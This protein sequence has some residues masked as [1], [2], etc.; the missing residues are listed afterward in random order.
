M[1]KVEKVLEIETQDSHVTT[2][3]SFQVLQVDTA[4]QVE[5]D[6]REIEECRVKRGITLEKTKNS[7][8][9]KG[10]ILEAHQVA[11]F[12]GMAETVNSRERCGIGIENHS[13]TGKIE[14]GNHTVERKTLQEKS[15]LETEDEAETETRALGKK[16]SIPR[17][18][19]KGKNTLE[20]D[21][22]ITENFRVDRVETEDPAETEN[23]S[24]ICQVEKEIS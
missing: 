22:A 12:K 13:A 19:S 20:K 3:I 23:S 24:G 7:K 10:I 5:I 8:V 4:V 2:E 9:E 18:G 14:G 16:D 21:Q 11:T 17:T 15:N 6:M 1:D